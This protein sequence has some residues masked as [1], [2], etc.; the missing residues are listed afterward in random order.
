MKIYYKKLNDLAHEPIKT[1]DPNGNVGYDLYSTEQVT[2]PP[3]AR[4]LVKTGI[5]MA[6]PK[7]YGG[8]L[9]PRS[10]NSVKYGSD[11]LA[12]VIDPSYR[13]EIGCV[14][15]NT[16]LNSTWFINIGDRICQ[17]VIQQYE[18]VDFVQTE[19]LS[20]T[21]RNNSGFGSSGF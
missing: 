19:D 16:C 13:G 17:M 8:F 4:R 2:I 6:I 3:G 10:G 15:L 20:Q 21:V 9:W 12:G 5:A 18:D 1:Y 11:V 14:L 7:G